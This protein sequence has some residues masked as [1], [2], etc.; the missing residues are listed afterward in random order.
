MGIESLCSAVAD[1]IKQED[2][3]NGI[4]RAKVVSD[5]IQVGG[6]SYYYVLAVEMTIKDGDWVYVMVTNNRAVVVGK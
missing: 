5:M 2:T 3:N 4:I 6:R 1:A